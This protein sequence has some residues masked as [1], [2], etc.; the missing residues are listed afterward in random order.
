[1]YRRGPAP[2]ARDP[3]GP[4]AYER[5]YDAPYGDRYPVADRDRRPM[6]PVGG[7][8]YDRRVPPTA[9]YPAARPGPDYRRRTPPPGPMGDT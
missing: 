3:Y 2:M 6:P 4:P 8:P 1:M 7:S 9:E 5:R